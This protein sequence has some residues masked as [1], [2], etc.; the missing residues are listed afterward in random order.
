MTPWYPAPDRPA[1]GVFVRE[2]ARAA[3]LFDDVALVH[4]AADESKR[5]GSFEL[6]RVPDE[7]FPVIRARYRGIRYAGWLVELAALARAV[8]SLR[9]SRFT[10]DVLHANIAARSAPAA[11]YSRLTRLPL[12]VS[13]HWSLYL[14]AGSQPVQGVASLFSHVAIK[15]A[16]KVL[17]VGCALKAAMQRFAPDARYE[18]VPNVIDCNLFTPPHMRPPTDRIQLIAVGL[19]SPDKDYPAML[20]AVR[21]LVH[22]GIPVQLQIVGYGDAEADLVRL[23]N[24]TG[25]EHH[26]ELAGYLSKPE[27]AERLRQSHVFVH[28]SRFETFCV[29]AAEALAAGIP[30]VSTRCGGPEEYVTPDSGLL[31]PVGDP[32]A[33]AAG[34]RTVIDQLDSF[35]P[36][37]IAT[38][39]RSRFAAEVVGQRLHETYASIVRTAA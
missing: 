11:L 10:P 32:D 14:D 21:Q 15:R 8:S 19:L 23:I 20:E 38:Q 36:S 37:R 22:T 6:E 13:E 33:L 27:I 25:L 39:A 12:I 29:A 2:H 35:N 31:V 9:E 16:T 30:V 28:S 1:A 4:L 3:A 34:I 7:P 24:R 26:V 17:P 5:P 18:V